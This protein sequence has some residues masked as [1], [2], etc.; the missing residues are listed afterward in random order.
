MSVK[1]N[2]RVKNTKET[3]PSEA[4]RLGRPE[5]APH[6]LRKILKFELWTLNNFNG[7]VSF[8]AGLFRQICEVTRTSS[9][10][11]RIHLLS[12]PTFR[13]T[14]DPCIDHRYRGTSTLPSLYRRYSLPYP[15]NCWWGNFD[16]LHEIDW[17]PILLVQTSWKDCQGDVKPYQVQE[18][19]LS[20]FYSYL[21]NSHVL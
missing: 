12:P 18:C 16:K 1:K 5:L 8:K 3:M 21:K 9:A 13:G 14:F 17:Y 4:G 15:Q 6:I 11:Q 10:L 19:E 2:V 7:K 20:Y